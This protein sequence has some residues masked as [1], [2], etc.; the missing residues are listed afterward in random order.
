[1]LPEEARSAIRSAFEESGMAGKAAK[2][3]ATA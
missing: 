3:L 2:V 1:V